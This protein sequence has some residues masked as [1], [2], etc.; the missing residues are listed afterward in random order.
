VSIK[1]KTITTYEIEFSEKKEIIAYGPLRQKIIFDTDPRNNQNIKYKSLS[2]QEFGLSE[3]SLEKNSIKSS[4]ITARVSKKNRYKLDM[5]RWYGDIFLSHNALIDASLA[6]A[7][8]EELKF[9]SE[10]AI[11]GEAEFKDPNYLEFLKIYYRTNRYI[12]TSRSKEMPNSFGL[13]DFSYHPTELISNL[14]WLLGKGPHTVGGY[15]KYGRINSRN[16]EIKKFSSLNLIIDPENYTKSNLAKTKIAKILN[17]Y[18]SLSK[19]NKV[20][21]DNCVDWIDKFQKNNYGL[22]KNI[23]YLF[24]FHD[25]SD[26]WFGKFAENNNLYLA[27]SEIGKS[28]INQCELDFEKILSNM[29]ENFLLHNKPEYVKDL[30]E[31]EIFIKNKDVNYQ[32]NLKQL[33][34][35]RLIISP[36][37]GYSNVKENTFFNF[38]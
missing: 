31:F 24:N 33:I 32:H 27:L 13:L 11:I 17:K 9:T 28:V 30:D 2:K 14:L 10:K 4:Y 29:R 15:I 18:F 23:Y 22:E 3:D 16:E 35:H 12:F 19:V 7:T 1:E 25:P 5:M 20:L 21:D 8:K 26:E 36:L 37:I 38:Y 34:R 6:F